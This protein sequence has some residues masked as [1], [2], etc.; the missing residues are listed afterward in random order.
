MLREE[1]E[2]Q[3]ERNAVVGV[4]EMRGDVAVIR[5]QQFFDGVPFVIG[6]D[7]RSELP[8]AQE[9]A[10]SDRQRG[11]RHPSPTRAA[12]RLCRIADQR[13]GVKPP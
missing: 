1:F 7:L 8:C 9:Y 6:E 10:D 11:E 12:R 5:L 13:S 3:R 2:K 4:A